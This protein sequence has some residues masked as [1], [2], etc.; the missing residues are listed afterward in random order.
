[1]NCEIQPLKDR[2]RAVDTL[3]PRGKVSE[4]ESPT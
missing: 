4:G 2:R 1:M 3:P